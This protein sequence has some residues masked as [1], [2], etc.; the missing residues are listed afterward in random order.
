MVDKKDDA[1]GATRFTGADLS[2]GIAACDDR[3]DYLIS[4]IL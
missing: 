1:S 3:G 4:T 2:R